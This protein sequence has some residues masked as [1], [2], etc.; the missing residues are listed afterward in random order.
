MHGFGRKIN[1]QK[2]QLYCADM[3]K[4]NW[5]DLRYVLAVAKEGSAA[6]A[7]RALN[8][9][10]ATVIRHIQ[11]FEKAQGLR[12][13]DHLASGYRLTPEGEIFLDAARSIDATITELERKIVGS[14]VELEGNVRLTTT[15]GLVPLLQEV[16]VDFRHLY[17]TITLDI[18][19][20]N[21]NVNLDTLD[22]DIAL[23]PTLNPPANLVG[24]CV[25]ELAFAIYGVKSWQ[26][27]NNGLFGSIHETPWLGL[28]EP[29]SA[30]VPGRWLND[31][32]DSALISVRCNSFINMLGLAEQGLG[33]ALLPC[34]L[35]DPSPT[36]HRVTPEPLP[37]RNQLWLLSH[38]DVLRSQRVQACMDFFYRRLHAKRLQLEG[39][40][41]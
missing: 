1:S 31:N 5:T 18:L 26:K 8:V 21:L 37:F 4:L 20:T 9:N 36:V 23:R 33:Y 35:G 14:D 16:L 41:P 11:A 29:L 28:N 10:H 39:E 34:Y 40:L 24:Q 15:D 7:A 27:K 12:L 25:C 3:H 17:P 19:I 6:A 32:I 22:A 30:S 38:R 2:K 13:F